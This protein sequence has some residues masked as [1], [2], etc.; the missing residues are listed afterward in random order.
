MRVLHVVR[1]YGPLSET[2]VADAISETGRLGCDCWLLTNSVENRHSF[3][4]PPDH[5]VCTWARP[6]W[7]VE[8][9][10]Q[11]LN[12]RLMRRRLAEAIEGVAPDVVHAQFG[13]SGRDVGETCAR[14]GLPLVVTFHGSDVTVYPD[15]RKR[16]RLSPLV[17]SRHNRYQHLFPFVT[18]A[19][20]VSEFVRKRLRDR[21]Y[22]GEI[23]TVPVG[24]RLDRFPHRP[25]RTRGRIELLFVGRLIPR[26]GLAT[27]LR[28]MT[29]LPKRHA[30]TTLTVVGDGPQRTSMPALAGSLGI[31]DR[32]RFRGAQTR[33]QV[34][35]A[36]WHADLLV[37]PSE[38]QPDG[39]A[40]TLGLVLL[41]AMATGLQVLATDCGGMREA[42]P[43]EFRREIVPEGNPVALAERLSD[44][45]D[46]RGDW[47]ARS[48][49]AREFVER[50]YS[51]ERRARETVDVYREVARP[52]AQR[53]T[54]V[55]ERIHAAPR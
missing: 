13:W 54:G 26:K 12:R 11:V 21:G 10:L 42:L 37:L 3:P 47:P 4:F 43:P 1:R 24:V 8:E 29:L 22:M 55:T 53:V 27:L 39:E 15:R 38:T 31:S 2:F 9:Q 40:E 17:R 46:R 52:T 49:L 5:K 35:G 50:E 19:L 33:S 7:L 45:L 6:H 36:L 20:V 23:H 32:V 30:S 16:E 44:L 28:A 51:W 25:P 41:E 48:Q 14:L 34:Q 18:R